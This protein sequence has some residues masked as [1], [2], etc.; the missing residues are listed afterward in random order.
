MGHTEASSPC[1]PFLI[2]ALIGG[3]FGGPISGT[4]SSAKEDNTSPISVQPVNRQF[5]R[6][7]VKSA[8][9]QGK[10]GILH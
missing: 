7:P 10:Q 9:E 4:H 5:D 1:R 2:R 3:F 8:G 6:H